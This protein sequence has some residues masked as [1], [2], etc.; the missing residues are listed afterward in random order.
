MLLAPCSKSNCRSRQSCRTLRVELHVPLGQLAGGLGD[1]VQEDLL[2]GGLT[3]MHPGGRAELHVAL[4]Q[5]A[6]GLG[7][8][9]KA[10]FLVGGLTC[11]LSRRPRAEL[12]SALVRPG[13]CPHMLHGACCRSGAR[14]SDG[15]QGLN[16]HLHGD[17]VTLGSGSVVTRQWL[18]GHQAVAW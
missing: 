13:R 2:P 7:D 10:G 14:S 8:R 5:V 6:G 11:M 18:G 16:V 1:R 17:G 12:C 15:L 3:C 4:G 9:I